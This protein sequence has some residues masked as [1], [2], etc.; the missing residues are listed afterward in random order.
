MKM[1][2]ILAVMVIGL[3]TTTLNADMR[4]KS[5]FKME[6]LVGLM[7]ME[8]TVDYMI[9]GDKA[10]TVNN[11][12]MTNK[13]M[14]FLG[15]GKPT[16]T[17]EIIRIDKEV[18][19]ELEM[20]DK[21]YKEQTFAQVRADIE[22]SLADSKKAKAKHLKDHPEDS[23]SYKTTFDVRKSGKSETIAGHATEQYFITIETYGK[24][25]EGG[26]GKMEIMMDTWLAKEIDNSEQVKFSMSLSEKLGFTGRN[27]QSLEGVLL[28]L[29]IDPNEIKDVM[30]DLEGVAL[31]SIT[32]ITLGGKNEEGQEGSGQL[33]TFNMQAT[34]VSTAAIAGSEFEIP[35]GYKL[36][37]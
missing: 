3:L 29:G 15:A 12:K 31:R 25:S 27:R 13:V 10:K 37:K 16:E 24:S 34:E 1:R 18:F 33:L 5:D 26:E 4:I 6:G 28:G 36:K 32:T 19:W 21:K 2:G 20:K 22:K 23:L 8:G 17:A 30:K 11:M 14:K 7:N 9:S 35:E